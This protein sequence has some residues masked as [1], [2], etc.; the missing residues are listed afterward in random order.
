MNVLK[1]IVNF[2][3]TSEIQQQQQQQQ[4]QSKDNS[5]WRSIWRHLDV[6][7]DGCLTPQQFHE[8][9]AGRG[10]DE[11]QIDELF[12]QLDGDCDGVVSEEEFVVLA[13][14]LLCEAAAASSSSSK[15]ASDAE[16]AGNN[17]DY[18]YY[19]DSVEISPKPRLNSEGSP[20][21]T[22]AE[23]RK[24]LNQLHGIFGMDSA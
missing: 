12:F 18:G 24:S 17:S 4:Q 19:S 20:K 10:M 9:L 6:E 8:R 2:V 3:L 13:E 14:Q 23:C 21:T 5:C 7:S 1:P 22:M 11:G 15:F 16:D